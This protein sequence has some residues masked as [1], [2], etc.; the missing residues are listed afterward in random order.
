M[1]TVNEYRARQLMQIW[2]DY[3]DEIL[4][5]DYEKGTYVSLV[6]ADE[7]IALKG[8]VDLDLMLLIKKRI[9]PDDAEKFKSFMDKKT[10][11]EA[12]EKGQRV[13]KLNFRYK[14]DYDNYVWVKV[15]NIIPEYQGKEDFVCFACFRRVDIETN[16]E[17]KATQELKDSLKSALEVSKARG[18]LLFELSREFRSPLQGIIGMSEI[19]RMAVRNPAKTY[20]RL[21][22]IESA[23]KVMAT[24]LDLILEKDKSGIVYKEDPEEKEEIGTLYDEKWDVKDREVR[25]EEPHE[26]EP[27]K[28]AAEWVPGSAESAGEVTEAAEEE[29]E[30]DFAGRRVLIVEDNLL[31]CEI[32]SEILE[33]TGLKV[34]LAD[35]GRK[36]V[37]NFVSKPVGYYDVILMDIE[38]PVLDGAEA[39]RCIRISGKDDARD[40]PIFAIS[41]STKKDDRRITKEGGFTANFQKPVD[42]KALYR[43]MKE[44][45]DGKKEFVV[46][47]SLNK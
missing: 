33:M 30:F 45:F 20:E 41:G 44:A 9:H 25:N 47:D 34:E 7:R 17:L 10:M 3:Y 39:T 11:L 15:K 32:M 43:R 4:E 12:R 6:T 28:P 27:S 8:F 1:E 23:A 5:I 19:A 22:K 2:R 14:S 42:F 31:N 24:Q 36:A 46:S 13:S 35:D 40:I 37:I 16:E 18:D 26:E 21:E 29:E 38:L